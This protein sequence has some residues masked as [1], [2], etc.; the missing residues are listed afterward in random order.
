MFITLLG[1]EISRKDAVALYAER[2]LTQLNIVD[3]PGGFAIDLG[4]GRRIEAWGTRQ[5]VS[6]LMLDMVVAGFM[7]RAREEEE[8]AG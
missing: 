7:A 3:T 6:D 1:C 4:K 8:H 2:R 5:E